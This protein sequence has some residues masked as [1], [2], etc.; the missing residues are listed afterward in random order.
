MQRD[1][2]YNFPST[3]AASRFY[4]DL[5]SSYV[6]EIR[7]LNVRRYPDNY[8][9]QLGYEP[10]TGGFDETATKLDE[11]AEAYAGREVSC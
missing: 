4:T 11:L 6:A 1:I 3:Q 7:P 9:V 8:H 5:R 2:R 10:M